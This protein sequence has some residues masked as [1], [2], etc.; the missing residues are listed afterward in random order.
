MI[1]G[2]TKVRGG[3]FVSTPFRSIAF[4]L[5]VTGRAVTDPILR[6]IYLHATGRIGSSF[7]ESNINST[8]DR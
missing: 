8:S 6:D 7:I 2:L 4:H 1:T 5:T 3:R